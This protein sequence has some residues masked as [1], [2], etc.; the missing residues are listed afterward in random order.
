MH[1]SRKL[2]EEKT[3]F[4]WGLCLA[5]VFEVEKPSNLALYITTLIVVPF[6]IFLFLNPRDF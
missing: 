6:I 3:H 4:L 5:F 2:E 1:F